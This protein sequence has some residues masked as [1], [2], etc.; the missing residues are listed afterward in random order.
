MPGTPSRF[1]DFPYKGKRLKRIGVVQLRSYTRAM[2]LSCLLVSVA[3]AATVR[4]AAP[5]SYHD[6]EIPKITASVQLPPPAKNPPDNRIGDFISGPDNPL[7][8]DADTKAKLEDLAKAYEKVGIDNYPLIIKT[9]KLEDKPASAK[10]VRIV[11]TYG[12]GGVAATSG[13]NQ[14]PRI[15]VS[16]RYALAHPD[17]VGLIVHEMVHVVQ[18][19]KHY[20]EADAPGWLVEGIADYVRWFF[21]EDLSKHPHP[22]AATADARGSY[23]TTA[24]FLFWASSRY[25][26]DLVPKLNAALQANTYKEELFKELTGKTLDELNAEWKSGLSSFSFLVLSF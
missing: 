14:G 22:K 16:A 2:Q 17:D 25:G 21:Y 6:I 11:V 15:E 8:V 26:A 24:A 5:V 18:N 1:A 3:A 7:V 19:Y 9:L 12:Y 20:N 23:R 10:N 13:T 4:S